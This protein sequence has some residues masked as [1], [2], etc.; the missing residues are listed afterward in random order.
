MSRS[1]SHTVMK[2]NNMHKKPISIAIFLTHEHDSFTP[3][4]IVY[5]FQTK[6]NKKST[7]YF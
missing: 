5:S 6:G 7:M 4:T 2:K 1:Y 3:F